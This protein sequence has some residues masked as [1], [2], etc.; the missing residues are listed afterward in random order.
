MSQATWIS[1]AVHSDVPQYRALPELTMSDMAHTVSS[2][3]V[4]GSARWQNRRSTKSR[5]KRSSD[6]SMACIRYFRLSVFFMFGS[7]WMPQKSLVDTT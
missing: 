5:P 3:G 6:P 7:S 4:V 1:S 2:I